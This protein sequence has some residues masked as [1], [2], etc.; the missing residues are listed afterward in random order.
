MRKEATFPLPVK[1]HPG[2]VLVG[3][4]FGPGSDTQSGW[5]RKLELEYK[6]MGPKQRQERRLRL[7][8]MM[9]VNCLGV[10]EF[11][12]EFYWETRKSAV[13]RALASVSGDDPLALARLKRPVLLLSPVSVCKARYWCNQCGTCARFHKACFFSWIWFSS[14]TIPNMPPKSQ[15]PMQ[16][17]QC[18]VPPVHPL[19]QID[20]P[21]NPPCSCATVLSGSPNNSAP[22]PGTNQQPWR[23]LS[24]GCWA[25]DCP[26][27]FNVP[28]E[29][30][31]KLDGL[32]H[33]VT[34]NLLG[35]QRT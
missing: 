21:R 1:E 34:R 4:V 33:L 6:F 31:L 15:P 3:L 29:D 16:V 32:G 28:S 26:P 35:A 8:L 30:Y 13:S 7:W 2:Y 17:F 14:Q 23:C 5:K 27:N 18:P 24:Q 12:Y 25:I 20:L 22:L 10:G 19:G 11:C 9:G